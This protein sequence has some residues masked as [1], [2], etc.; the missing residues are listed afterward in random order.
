MVLLEGEVLSFKLMGRFIFLACQDVPINGET[1]VGVVDLAKIII[2]Q[3]REL[4]DWPDCAPMF[5]TSMPSKAQAWGHR[6][7]EPEYSVRDIIGPTK[8]LD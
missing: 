2:K 4:E 8:L 5:S 6:I 7:G 1:E 3:Q